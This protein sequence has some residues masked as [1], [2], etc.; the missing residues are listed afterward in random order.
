MPRR[1]KTK[2][3][4]DFVRISNWA[5]NFIG[6]ITLAFLLAFIFGNGIPNFFELTTRENLLLLSLFTIII[7]IIYSFWKKIIAGILVLVGSFAFWSINFIFTGNAWLGFYFWFF[8][9]LGISYLYIWYKL[10][11]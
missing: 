8:P 11:K 2:F 9:I 7:G 1:K 6:I 5:I 3:K 4:L 10:K